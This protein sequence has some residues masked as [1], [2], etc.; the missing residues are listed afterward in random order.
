VELYRR[1]FEKLGIADA[2]AELGGRTA[3]ARVAA[4]AKSTGAK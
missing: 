3:P 2:A 1:T 4:G